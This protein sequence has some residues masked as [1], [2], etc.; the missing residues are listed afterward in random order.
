MRK[1]TIKNIVSVYLMLVMITSL[2][3][4]LFK[5]EKI[6]ETNLQTVLASSDIHH[7]FG[8]DSLGRDLFLRCFYGLSISFI[9][10]IISVM[11][12]FIIGISVGAFSGLIG[13]KVDQLINRVLEVLISL[14]SLMIMAV[15]YLV[16]EA[17]FSLRDHSLIL[18]ILVL[19]LSSWM[20]IARFV[21]NLV[22][23]EKKELYVEA[24]YSLGARGF[25][26][27]W[28]HILPNMRSALL[29]YFSLQIPQ[30]LMAEGLLSFLG[31][32]IQA[33]DVS[34]GALLQDGW[35]TMSTFPRLLLAPGL[36]LFFT[37]Y[38]IYYLLDHYRYSMDPQLK[39][40][41]FN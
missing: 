32:G 38:S 36:I 41:K 5:P 37:V 10:G 34:I 16:L 6:F 7:I 17:S 40:E 21:R 39:W 28:K 25:R 29:V 30:A 9:T 12:A 23:K 19:A 15:L 26:V 4:F 35:K 14:P 31:L 8:T 24:A 22:L 33:P 3:I 13:G 18:M 27:F 1:L 2:F 20:S 11:L